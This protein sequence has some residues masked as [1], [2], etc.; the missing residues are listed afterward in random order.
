MTLDIIISLLCEVISVSENDLGART[1][2]TQEY[3]IEPIDVAKLIIE[4]EKHFELT[5]HDEDIHT[6]EVVNDVVK[7]VDA[8]IAE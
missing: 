4:V 3:G 7:Y 1:P 5:I 8:L 2:L 6:F